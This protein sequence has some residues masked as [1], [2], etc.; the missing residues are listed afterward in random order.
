MKEV[1]DSMARNEPDVLLLNC[2][3]PNHITAGLKQL[4]PLW[5]KP[6]G[7]YAHVGK[8]N[9]PEWQ[10][11]D[12]YN[13]DQHLHE[14]KKWHDLGATVIGGCCGTTPAYIKKVTEFFS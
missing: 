1:A 8:F 9:P 11:T 3:P 5:N 14:C 13:A 2:A 10:F 7:V 6:L 4:A 12:E